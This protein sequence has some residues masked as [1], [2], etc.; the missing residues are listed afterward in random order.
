M[1]YRIDDFVAK[2]LLDGLRFERVRSWSECATHSHLRPFRYAGLSLEREITGEDRDHT[3][4]AIV[5]LR[6]T[7]K[8]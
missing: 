1:I 2:K 6:R 3:E 7:R 5:K 4:E 8:L